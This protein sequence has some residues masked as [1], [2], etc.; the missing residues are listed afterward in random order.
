VPSSPRR[1]TSRLGCWRV[2]ATGVLAARAS[3]DA[4]SQVSLCSRRTK[5][6]QRTTERAQGDRKRQTKR[7]DHVLLGASQLIAF[8]RRWRCAPP[9]RP[10]TRAPTPRAD[11]ARA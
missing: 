3:I 11:L 6:T 9:C 4:A 8:G 1:S 7:N 10:D 2:S 5:T